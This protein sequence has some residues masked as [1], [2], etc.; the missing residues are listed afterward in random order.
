MFPKRVSTK[1]NIKLATIYR[2]LNN[3]FLNPFMEFIRK[4]YVCQ[5]QVKKG[6][7]GLKDAVNYIKNG[8]S[9]ALM[10]DQRLGEGE[11][12]KFFNIFMPPFIAIC[13]LILFSSSIIYFYNPFE[14]IE[15]KEQKNPE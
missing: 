11:K 4:K 7:H 6:I 15:K 14:N 5:N 10:V 2:P 1:K 8:F 12:V 9:L 3:I 13:S